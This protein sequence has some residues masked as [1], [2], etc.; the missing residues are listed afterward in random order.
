MRMGLVLFLAP[1]IARAHRRE[2]RKKV[3]LALEPG[4]ISDDSDYF[5]KVSECSSAIG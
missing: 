4:E 2:T 5:C 1:T 3:V